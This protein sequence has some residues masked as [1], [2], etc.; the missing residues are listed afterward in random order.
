MHTPSTAI[1]EFCKVVSRV[2][3]A[4]EFPGYRQVSFDED[5]GQGSTKYPQSLR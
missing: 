5:R 2:L 3:T 4:W 1:H